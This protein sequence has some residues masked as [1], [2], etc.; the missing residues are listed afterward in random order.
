[1]G[2]DRTLCQ[3]CRDVPVTKFL[4]L[5]EQPACVFPEN[6]EE[7]RTEQTWPL[8]LGFC[9]RCSLVQ[10]MEP[11]SERVLFSGD[12]HHLAGLTKGFREHLVELAAVLAAQQ[13][14]DPRRRRVIEIGS[15]DGS[16]LD[17]L[18]ERGFNV[19]GVDPCGSVSPNGSPVVTDYF[20]AELAQRMMSSSR[21]ANIVV[22][23]NT[24]AHVTNLRDFLDGLC[25]ILEADGM[26]VSESH[27]LPEMLRTLQY[28][29]AYHEHSRYYSLTAL[30]HVFGLHGLEVFHVE[31]VDTHGGSV[32][33]YAGFKGAHQIRDSVT[34]LRRA[35]DAQKLTDEATYREFAARVEDHRDRFRHLV[36]KLA[37]DGSRIAGSSCPARAVT[38]LNYCS[39]GPADISVVSEISPLKIGRLFPG[40][41][42]PVISQ[43]ELCGPDQPDYAI[44]FSWHILDELSARLRAEG[45]RG[46]FVVPLPEPQVLSEP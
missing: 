8:D 21:P 42:I 32:R 40:V 24:F 9:P 15:N 28:D 12:Y 2:D 17:A 33:V 37:G 25:T 10:V 27:Y 6:H 23:T 1:M 19:L 36:R 45:F 4:S 5:G 46:K 34:E 35:E 38:L 39:L 41:H 7:A 14:P 3:T 11:V 16:L 31:L 13:D 44:L 26:F 20:S 29:F 30:Q 43:E 18:A 22:A